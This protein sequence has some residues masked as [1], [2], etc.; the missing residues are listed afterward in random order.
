MTI[1]IPNLKNL[2]LNA[3]F[4]HLE[5][6][7]LASKLAFCNHLIR[8]EKPDIFDELIVAMKDL[9]SDSSQDNAMAIITWSQALIATNDPNVLMKLSEF[10]MTQLFRGFIHKLDLSQLDDNNM[11]AGDAAVGASAEG[12]VDY[13][14]SRP[15]KR[16]RLIQ[17]TET[18]KARYIQSCINFCLFYLI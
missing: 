14:S 12:A 11:A 1:N 3:I 9:L 16:R 2:S 15:T 10:Q 4:Q 13:D 18:I 17:N 5:P 7:D 6:A 8:L